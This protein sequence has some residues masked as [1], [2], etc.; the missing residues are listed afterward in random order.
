MACF[1]CV[2]P[3]FNIAWRTSIAIVKVCSFATWVVE[4]ID[5]EAFWSITRDLDIYFLSWRVTV[6]KE[7]GDHPGHV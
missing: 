5:Q 1:G 4:D 7:S 3:E 6:E 2:K